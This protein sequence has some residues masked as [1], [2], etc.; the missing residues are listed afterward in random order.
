MCIIMWKGWINIKTEYLLNKEV[1]HVLALLTPSNQLIIQVCLH[2]GLR[3]SDVLCL[4]PEQLKPRFWITEQKTGKRRIVGLPDELRE[5]IRAQSGAVWCFPHRLDETK[6]KTRQA[7]WKDVKRAARLLRL[8]QNAA[9]H[10]FR[11]V[12]AVDLL[13]KYGDIAKVRRALNHSSDSVTAI[14]AMAAQ[15]LETKQLKRACR[16][17]RR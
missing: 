2:T 10:S 14:Y 6:H 5:K 8:K 7:V 12:Y 1:E 11:K 16:V 3:L 9:P 15:L 4:K 17:G 13:N